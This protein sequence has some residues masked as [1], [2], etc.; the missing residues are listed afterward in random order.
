ML[1]RAEVLVIGVLLARAGALSAQGHGA[2]RI[3]TIDAGDVATIVLQVPAVTDTDS[4]SYT[5]ELEDGFQAFVP[6]TGRVDRLD[7]RFILPVTFATPDRLAAGRV[8]AGRVAVEVGDR[9]PVRRELAV[10]VRERRELSFELGAAEVTVAPDGVAGV[11]YHAHN[12][13]NLSDTLY[14]DVRAGE[15]WALLGAPRLVLAPGDSALGVLRIAAPV[16]VSPGDRELLLVNARTVAGEQT[17]TLNAVIVSPAG[18]LGDLAQVPGSVFIG[19]ALEAGQGPVVAVSGG[20]EIGPDTDVRIELRHSDPDLVDPALQRQVAGARFRASL[21]RPGLEIEAGDVYGTE[22]TLS[23][24]LRQARGVRST[25]DPRGP[26]TF[27]AV[28]AMPTGFGGELDG[29]HILYGETGLA[30]AYGQFDVLAGDM[31]YPARG[32]IAETRTSGAGLRW[33]GHL[34]PH[35]GSIE[36]SLVRFVAADSLVRFGPAL[37]L[38]YHLA[39][40]G[41]NGRFRLR[42]VPDAATGPGGQGNELSGSLS[43]ELAP[44]VYLVGWGYRTDQKLL[45]IGTATRSYAGNLGVRTR[46]GRFQMQLGGTLSDRRTITAVDSF[47]FARNTVRAEATYTRGALSIQAD[48]RIGTA[49][50][51]DRTGPYRSFGSS[52]RW[53]GQGRWGWLRMQYSA[54][55]GGIVATDIHAGGAVGL[56]PVHVSGGLSTSFIQS[57]NIT[58]FWSSTEF[59]VQRNLAVHLGASARPSLDRPDWTFSI[60]VSRRLNLPLPVA[61][62]PDLHGVVFD[63]AD[64]D[65]VRDP[66]EPGVAGVSVALGHLEAAT[67]GDGRFAFR[68]RTGVRLRLRSGTLPIGFLPSPHAVLPSRGEASIPLLRAAALQLQLFLDR[69]EDG[70]HDNAEGPASGAIVT[71]TD[72]R[73]RQR[74]ATADSTGA[75]HFTGLLPGSY[76]VTAR[77]ASAPAPA[78]D[79][80]VLMEIELEPGSAAHHTLAVPLRRRTIRMDGGDGGGFQ[81][82]EGG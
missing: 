39:A 41:T 9:E 42:R 15:G 50:E 54:R 63:D 19:Q 11:T 74:T 7:D 44:R 12:L 60:G 69:D 3:P 82:F 29:G 45:G 51:L 35:E 59:H 62:R 13:G 40:D 8:V 22:T 56:G 27:H 81:F 78:E 16:T 32:T 48:A 76:A 21:A 53:Y 24:S 26:L 20:G 66:D 23:G 49:A 55:P 18:W 43:T 4:A 38:R 72:E 68:D 65:G 47:T 1:R 17:R 71:V 6:V 34:G 36:T 52:V 73:G 30:T 10:R 61:R 64:N 77:P 67:D 33:G 25:W 80:E 14:L 28:A 79:P 31:R 75:V 58:S 2:A 5:L 70:E 37:D 46:V 57:T